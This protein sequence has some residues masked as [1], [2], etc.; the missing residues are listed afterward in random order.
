MP[1]GASGESESGDSDSKG[2]LKALERAPH[3]LVTS[4]AGLCGLVVRKIVLLLVVGVPGLAL[5]NL[6]ELHMASKS[7]LKSDMNLSFGAS[8]AA[9]Q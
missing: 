7:G 8:A 5:S 3:V 2:Q 6:M 1:Q 4:G 9:L